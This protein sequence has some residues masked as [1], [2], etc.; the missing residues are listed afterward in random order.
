MGRSAFRRSQPFGGRLLALRLGSREWAA[1][2]VSPWFGAGYVIVIVTSSV[3]REVPGRLGLLFVVL[4]A[5]L[6]VRPREIRR[7]EDVAE[8]WAGTGTPPALRDAARQVG[9]WYLAATA[10]TFTGE[11]PCA[12]R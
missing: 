6:V 12:R 7:R 5:L 10:I 9:G 11:R 1:R 2:R 8:R 4:A 3:M